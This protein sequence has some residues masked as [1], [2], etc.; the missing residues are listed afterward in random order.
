[1]L[2]MPVM[3]TFTK[4]AKSCARNTLKASTQA[5]R[6]I[7]SQVRLLPDFLIIGAQRCGTSSLYYYMVEHPSII[8]AYTKELHYFDEKYKNGLTWYR[9]QFP[10]ML[11]KYYVERIRSLDFLTGEAS[12]YY[13][14][15]PLA[16]KRIARIM[17]QVKLIALLRNPVDRAYSQYWIEYGKHEKL[18]FEEAIA[19]EEERVAGEVEKMLKDESYISYNHRHYTYLARGIYADQI[20]NWLHFFPK[21]QLLVLKSEDLYKDPAAV[22]KTTFDFL[23]LPG[24]NL[25]KEFKNYVR[26]H[27][28]G[29]KFQFNHPKML[30]ETRQQLVEYFRQHN[31]RLSG[32]LRRDFSWEE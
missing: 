26:P 10:S 15:H 11:H 12:P 20:Q 21:E 31:Q 19:A 17:P 5:Y 1:M 14:F 16:P 23:G 28:K 30:P 27:K 2:R 25:N 18:S 8:P 13:L 4:T 32:L 29:Y 24:G 6:V 22:L 3:N 7:T 9:A